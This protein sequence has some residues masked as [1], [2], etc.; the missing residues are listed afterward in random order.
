MVWRIVGATA[1]CLGIVVIA[2]TLAF[3][4]GDLL[5]EPSLLLGVVLAIGGAVI[6]LLAQVR[7]ALRATVDAG[8]DRDPAP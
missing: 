6:V 7:D 2:I 5:A 4:S 8:I 3:A 1:L